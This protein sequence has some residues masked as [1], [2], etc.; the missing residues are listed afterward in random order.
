MLLL[1]ENRRILSAKIAL[2][3]LTV[4]PYRAELAENVL[5]GEVADNESVLRAA[6]QMASAEHPWPART[7]LHA[8]AAFRTKT[9]VVTILRALKAARSR[10]SWQKGVSLEGD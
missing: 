6:A 8:T 9:A 7:D 2:G 10:C 3:G 5:I 4:N 1:D